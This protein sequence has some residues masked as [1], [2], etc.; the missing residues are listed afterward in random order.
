LVAAVFPN[1]KLVGFAAMKSVKNTKRLFLPGQRFKPKQLN[2]LHNPP[3]VI[4]G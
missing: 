2:G 1:L 4:Q 3:N